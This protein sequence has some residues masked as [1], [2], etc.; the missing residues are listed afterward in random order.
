MLLSSVI[1]TQI[2]SQ[3]VGRRSLPTS[4]DQ[5]TS[6]TAHN[7]HQTCIRVVSPEDG[8]VMPD[9]FRDF[10]PKQSVSES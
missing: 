5:P 4:R 3:D 10:E 7:I 1:I 8:Q 6:T 2:W 9:T